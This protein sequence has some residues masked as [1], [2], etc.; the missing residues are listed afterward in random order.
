MGTAN[1][2]RPHMG[3]TYARVAH[4]L[5]V[6][7]TPKGVFPLNQEQLAAVE[8][9]KSFLV[10]MHLLAVPDEAAAV[11]AA[12]AFVAGDPPRGRLYEIG[13]DTSK[14]AAGSVMGQCKEANNP[15][16]ILM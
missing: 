10:E 9:L 4:P 13:A 8:K 15:L 14:I 7:L 6:L 1:Y 11:E 16:S 2:A 5:R 3:P 12:T